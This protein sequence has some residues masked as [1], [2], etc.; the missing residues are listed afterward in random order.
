MQIQV[1][2]LIHKILSKLLDISLWMKKRLNKKF[3]LS[4]N[5]AKDVSH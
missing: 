4:S 1:W 5:K 3:S 2:M